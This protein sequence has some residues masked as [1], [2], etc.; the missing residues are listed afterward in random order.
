MASIMATEKASPTSA[1]KM[2]PDFSLPLLTANGGRVELG[3]YRGKI[4]ALNFW[5]SW[6][7]A[8]RE[9]RPILVALRSRTS[10]S[11]LGLA[12]SDQESEA[13][14][15]EASRPHGH[16]VAFDIESRVADLYGVK[17]LPT[18]I[19][20]GADGRILR[21]YPRMLLEGDVEDLRTLIRDAKPVALSPQAIGGGS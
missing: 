5:A 2:A 14:A 16:L 12:T 19:L 9:E 13:M 3:H 10:I 11:V 17:V 4:V 21:R 15:A 1:G 8:C 20:I 6:C 7:G 18:T